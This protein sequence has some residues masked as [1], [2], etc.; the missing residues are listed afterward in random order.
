MRRTIVPAFRFGAHSHV[1]IL[2]LVL[3]SCLA[4]GAC[5]S[6]AGATTWQ[7][8]TA[9][10][11][12]DTATVYDVLAG[13]PGFVAVGSIAES[14]HMVAA[15]WT[16]ADGRTWTRGPDDP[17]LKDRLFTHVAVLGSVVL[18]LAFNCTDTGECAGAD[19]WTSPDGLTWTLASTV[20]SDFRGLGM[21]ADSTRVVVL[22]DS[23]ARAQWDLR[24]V[25]R[26]DLD[27]GRLDARLRPASPGCPRVRRA[28]HR[29]RRLR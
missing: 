25:G 26:E 20:T 18:A 29:G 5:Q 24:V 1:P 17:Q 3:M 2:A 8:V 10:S 7:P 16:S 19:I 21:A 11:A 14:G 4:L 9:L 22:G 27:T 13:G 6:G 23:R 12:F 15:S 28:G